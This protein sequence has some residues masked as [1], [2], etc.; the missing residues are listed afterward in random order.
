MRQLGVEISG[1][2]CVHS[3]T[4][5]SP[6]DC[7]LS[8]QIHQ[9]RFARRIR[10]LKIGGRCHQTMYRC[11][12]NDASFSTG[13]HVLGGERRQK[14]TGVEVHINNISEGFDLRVFRGVHCIS[15]AGV[16]YQ[17]IYLAIMRNGLRNQ[18][19]TLIVVAHV[20]LDC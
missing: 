1:T 3:H 17:H 2:K 4:P 7:E 11:D 12:V 9:A 20:T 13:Q 18:L 6:L 10:R 8:G 14:K 15:D 19:A 5:L 16:I